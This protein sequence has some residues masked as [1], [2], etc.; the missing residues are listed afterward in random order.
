MGHPRQNM[1]HLSCVSISLRELGK[2][3]ESLTGNLT[4]DF[5]NVKFHATYYGM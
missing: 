3:L 4:S 1:V 5:F 2:M